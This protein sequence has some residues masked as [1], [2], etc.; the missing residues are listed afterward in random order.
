MLRTPSKFCTSLLLLRVCSCMSYFC[1]VDFFLKKVFFVTWVLAVG[2]CV[3]EW[4][5]CSAMLSCAL[6]FK[7]LKLFWLRVSWN[8]LLC[9]SSISWSSWCSS[10]LIL[11]SD[12]Y[13]LILSWSPFSPFSS[14]FLPLMNI[15]VG[16]LLIFG[17]STLVF[18]DF[19]PL[20]ENGFVNR[21]GNL[22]FFYSYSKAL[23]SS[24]FDSSKPSSTVFLALNLSAYRAPLS[25]I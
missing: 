17:I 19:F 20:L 16:A 25:L 13:F 1:R 8:Y 23:S 2:N 24:F 11:S 21:S 4:L 22:I 18:E 7:R 6:G 14:L 10:A 12:C 15:C 9:S 5:V 3:N